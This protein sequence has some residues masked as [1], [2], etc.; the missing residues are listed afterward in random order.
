M[1]R[2]TPPN[3]ILVSLG[4]AFQE[5]ITLNSYAPVSTYTRTIH[6]TAPTSAKLIFD[7]AGGDN[8]G[9]LLDNVG[10]ERN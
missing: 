10:L 7:H 9:L 3:T 4:D 1:P 8:H 2:E 5:T 6:V